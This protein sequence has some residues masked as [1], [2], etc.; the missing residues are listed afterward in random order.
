MSSTFI[1]NQE[2]EAL[3]GAV[4]LSGGFSITRSL[5]VLTLQITPKPQIIDKSRTMQITA[6][7]QQLRPESQLSC[8]S[9]KFY[10]SCKTAKASF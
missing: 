2:G 5:V 4:S 3:P 6:N 8:S 7:A 10:F 9:L 1:L